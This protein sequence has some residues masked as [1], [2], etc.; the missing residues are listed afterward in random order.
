VTA[1]KSRRPRILRG[2]QPT[3]PMP[4]LDL[5]RHTPYRHARIPDA[6]AEDPTVRRGLDL[7]ASV[8]ELMLRCGAGAPQVE[9]SVA[10]VAA[11]AGLDQV[12]LDIT[13]ESLIIQATSRDGRTH[14]LLRVVRRT[15]FDYARLVAVHRLVETLVAGQVTPDQAADRLRAIERHPRNFPSWATSW[16]SALLAAAV[17][18]MIGASLLVAAVTIVV[19]LA[20]AGLSQ[21]HGRIDL[22]EFYRNAINALF[23]TLMAGGFFALGVAGR[24]AIDGTDFAFVVA[25]GIVAML[26]GRT[27]AAA[28]EDVLF[29]YPLT[30]AGRLL[31]V[32]LSLT[33]LIIGIAMGLSVLLTITEVV[34]ADFVSPSV[35]DLR[36]AQ[37]PVVP[38]LLG[39]LLVGLA[40][41][42]MAQSRR[43]LVLP[44]GLLTVAGFGVAALLVRVV[45]IGVITATGLAAVALGIVGRV[46]AQRLN[47]PS[48]VLV[49]PA[50]FGLL[51]GLAIFRGL[52]E[53]VGSGSAS[54][55]LTIQAG[56]ATLLGAGAVL[57]AIATGTVFGEILASPLDRRS[58]GERARGATGGADEADQDRGSWGD[59]DHGGSSR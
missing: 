3:E 32:L 29:G 36:V 13:L 37:A 51:P 55:A 19:V 26:P 30:G 25:G 56:I 8:G 7:A 46:V 24:I 12:D 39:A 45:G 15:R 54:G 59:D 53:L 20:V 38:A 41:A 1:P 49:V 35:L 21:L 6:A 5:L 10:A 52:Y 42:V 18:V 27:M 50:T 34:G 17:A 23:A 14:T 57:L 47:A 2:E 28:I 9:G 31:H 44:T 33:G 22:P 16:A 11:A 48:M 43:M 4:M 40:A 58:R